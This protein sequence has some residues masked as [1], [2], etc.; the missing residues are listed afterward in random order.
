MRKRLFQTLSYCFPATAADLVYHQLTHPA[1]ANFKAAEAQFLNTASQT[2]YTFRRFSIRTYRWGN[3]P[4]N[5]L[6]IHGWEGQSG[7]F[8]SLVPE[9]VQ[10]GFTVYAFDG[11]SHG[12]SSRGR[13]GLPEFTELIATL[14][15][16]WNITHAVSHSF[17]SVSMTYALHLHKQLSLQAFVLV[18]T[19]DKFMERM[20]E[21]RQSL[22]LSNRAIEKLLQKMQTDS[23]IDAA[24][25]NV[26]DFVKQ[27]QVGRALVLHDT[28]DRILPVQRSRNVAAA[29][30]EAV[31]EE[32]E[33]TGHFKILHTPAVIQRIG[34]FLKP[35]QQ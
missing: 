2:D 30:K 19:P 14:M 26:S 27:I 24:K 28:A 33:G 31:M 4:E 23:G 9:L 29:W 21:A 20:E 13:T 8:S 1:K 35:D 16:E 11:P 3:G 32:V 12:N 34:N 22:G 17:G 15:T 18:T 5:V 7:N 25:L 6:L 10:R